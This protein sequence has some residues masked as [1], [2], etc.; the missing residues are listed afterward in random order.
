MDNIG[1]TDR[2]NYISYIISKELM[3]IWLNNADEYR[4]DIYALIEI[5]CRLLGYDSM[6][7]ENIRCFKQYLDDIQIQDEYALPLSELGE[8]IYKKNNVNA[9]DSKDKRNII[10]NKQE[11]D[12]DSNNP[13]LLDSSL[14]SMTG[15]EFEALIELLLVNMGLDVRITKATGDGGIDLVAYSNE[16][17]FKGKYI[18]QC[19]RWS[20]AVGEPIIRDL[21]GVIMAERA[22]KGILITTSYFTDQAIQFAE[23]KNIELIGY[24]ALRKLLNDYEINIGN[25]EN[26][27]NIKKHFK[28]CNGFDIDKYDYLKSKLEDNYT[29]KLFYDNLK[30]FYHKY[31]LS[32]NYEINMCGLFDEYINL[33]KETIKRF[34]RKG[35]K[36]IA[37][38]KAY[39]YINAYIYILKGELFKALEILKD[40]GLLNPSNNMN[41]SATSYKTTMIF[42][43]EDLKRL[44]GR[45]IIS[46]S[47]YE[48]MYKVDSHSPLVMLKNLYLLFNKTHFVEG[49][50]FIEALMLSNCECVQRS[51]YADFGILMNKYKIEDTKEIFQLIKDNNYNKFHHLINTSFHKNHNKEYELEVY[52]K[53]DIFLPIDDLINIYYMNLENKISDEVE[54]CKLLLNIGEL[55]AGN[56]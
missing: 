50:D 22:N 55:E 44:E 56:R 23:G 14:K 7:I 41:F 33:N 18:I 5:Y 32:N 11:E 40:I 49:I 34:C 9:R 53:E 16:S 25:V 46:K 6:N 47:G 43:Q 27:N 51:K 39:R 8:I 19:K 36:N 31:I 15:I 4:E 28:Y 13:A 3:E 17:F 21:Y 2:Y 29:E 48:V 10:N 1:T 52:F 26:L 12:S 37:E 35:S 24:D 30:S 38:A 54:K 20:G 42:F 45:E